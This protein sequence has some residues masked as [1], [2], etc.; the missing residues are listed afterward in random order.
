[1]EFYQTGAEQILSKQQWN[2][3]DDLYISQW[4]FWDKMKFLERVMK[5]TKSID[6]LSNKNPKDDSLESD[7]EEESTNETSIET[8][9]PNQKVKNW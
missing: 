6:N 4:T 7:E 5:N 9:T 3:P 1:M 2:E 8:S